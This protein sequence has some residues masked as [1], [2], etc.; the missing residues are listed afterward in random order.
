VAIGDRILD[1]RP[2]RQAG[3]LGGLRRGDGAACSARVL[4]PLMA[5]GRAHWSPLRKRLGELLRAGSGHRAAVEP[6]L[7]PMA[8]S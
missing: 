4:N 8:K 7:V 5:L 3:L 6:L 2:L 1:L